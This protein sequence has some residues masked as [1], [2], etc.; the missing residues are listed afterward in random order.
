MIGVHRNARVLRGERAPRLLHR[1]PARQF[2]AIHCDVEFRE[3]CAFGDAEAEGANRVLEALGRVGDDDLPLFIFCLRVIG[4][5][6][7]PLL[8]FLAGDADVFSLG[9]LAL[10]RRGPPGFGSVATRPDDVPP[11]AATRQ[12]HD[13]AANYDPTRS[14]RTPPRVRLFSAGRDVLGIIHHV[15]DRFPDSVLIWQPLRKVPPPIG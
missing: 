14:V 9:D 2:Q 4:R 8:F 6:S 15:H 10:G 7:G 5:G 12:K 1:C 13:Y 11:S 3:V